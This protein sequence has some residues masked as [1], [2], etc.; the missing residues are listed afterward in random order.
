MVQY[1]ESHDDENGFLKE[2]DVL[3]KQALKDGKLHTANTLRMAMLEL[4]RLYKI[5]RM[6]K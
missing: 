5:E 4:K 1:N 2:L 3:V 6:K